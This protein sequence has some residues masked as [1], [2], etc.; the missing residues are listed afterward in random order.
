MC[1]SLVFVFLAEC[2]L[3]LA[4]CW[5]YHGVFVPVADRSISPPAFPPHVRVYV[6]MCVCA[7][8]RVC[9]RV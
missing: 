3:P 9:M 7:R 6:C 2:R 5:E 4:D 1:V 8:A